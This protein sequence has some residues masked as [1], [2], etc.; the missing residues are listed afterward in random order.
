MELFAFRDDFKLSCEVEK[1]VLNSSSLTWLFSSRVETV[2]EMP[3]ASIWFSSDDFNDC[4]VL[5]RVPIGED[6]TLTSQLKV[7][8]T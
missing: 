2:A 4:S 1:M 6:S 3:A 8:P 7:S 5:S